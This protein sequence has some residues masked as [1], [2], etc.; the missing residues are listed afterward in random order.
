[1]LHVD[2]PDGHFGITILLSCPMLDNTLASVSAPNCARMF[3][4]SQA[5]LF[6]V[7]RSLTRRSSND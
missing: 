7:K 2:R 3:D 1:M 5:C 6:R 4:L